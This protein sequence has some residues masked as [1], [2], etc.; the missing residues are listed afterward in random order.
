M[1]YY[2]LIKT[3][4]KG[5]GETAMWQSTKLVSDALE[6]MKETN[7]EAYWALIK[8]TYAIMAGPHYNEEFGEW[9]IAQMSYKDKSGTIHHSPHWTKAQY[10]AVYDNI[11]PKLKDDKY[12]AWDVAVTLEM[13]YSDYICTL[14]EWFPAETDQELEARVVQLAIAY[15]NDEDD[16]TEGKIWRRF[17]A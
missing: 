4:G 12:T 10:A 3:Y 6:P 17:N 1:T 7:P 13:L 14:R 2:D 16:K 9:Q 8:N 5:R 15:L 11:R